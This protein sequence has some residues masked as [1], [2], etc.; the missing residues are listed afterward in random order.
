MFFQHKKR[1]IFREMN[2]KDLRQKIYIGYRSNEKVATTLPFPV[3]I[4]VNL[5]HARFL[6]N[7]VGMLV[8]STTYCCRF[9][10]WKGQ[11][12]T[13]GDSISPPIRPDLIR[14]RRSTD[15]IFICVN[16]IQLSALSRLWIFHHPLNVADFEFFKYSSWTDLNQFDFCHCRHLL[17][18]LRSL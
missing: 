8:W 13:L 2:F 1:K 9:K 14:R 18:C 6:R 15:V 12:F 10:N 16:G 3:D 17:A 4:D 5:L 11:K 7:L